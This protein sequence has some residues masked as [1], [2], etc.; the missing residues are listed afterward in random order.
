MASRL[1]D[2]Y[3]LLGN[4]AYADAQD[5]TIGFD[6]NDGQIREPGVVDFLL[7]ESVFFL[8]GRGVVSVAGA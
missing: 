8:V 1:S 6:T 5:P 7:Y 2:L 3:S 4:E